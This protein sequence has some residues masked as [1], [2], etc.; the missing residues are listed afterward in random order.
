M[1]MTK[2]AVFVLIILSLNACSQNT[3]KNAAYSSSEK[4]LECDSLIED[5]KYSSAYEMLCESKEDEYILAKKIQI[6]LENSKENY[7]FHHFI[8]ADGYGI[9]ENKKLIVFDIIKEINKYQ[10]KNGI[11]GILQLYAGHYYQNLYIYGREYKETIMAEDDI[12]EKMYNHYSVAISMGYSNY[13][14]CRNYADLNFRMGNYDM[15]IEY[16]KQVIDFDKSFAFDYERL[17]SA[18]YANGEYEKSIEA[19]NEYLSQK[20][21]YSYLLFYYYRILIYNYIKLEDYDKMYEYII[22]AEQVEKSSYSLFS[23][24]NYAFLSIGEYEKAKEE[25]NKYVYHIFEDISSYYESEKEHNKNKYL[26]D[27]IDMLAYFFGNYE[28]Y[29]DQLNELTNELLLEYSDNEL[30]LEIIK[31]SNG[32]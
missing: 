9:I 1:K 8:I 28:L 27:T 6:L 29:N 17:A 12:N 25:A 19:V 13:D 4:L 10:R 26:N 32:I 2:I 24:K 15:S 23:L 14:L 20:D 11:S 30:M 18:Y 7:R 21:I 5:G 22:K 16:Y 31:K 3:N